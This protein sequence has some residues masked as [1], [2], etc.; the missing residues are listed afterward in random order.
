MRKTALLFRSTVAAAVFLM[1]GSSYAGQGERLANAKPSAA[2]KTTTVPVTTVVTALGPNFTA[3]PAISKDDVAVYS[4]NTRENVAS[5]DAAR[6]AK[7]GLQ[8]AILIDDDDSPTALG[9]HF[10]EIKDFIG[11]QPP[12]TEVG[13]Y[14][15]SAGS[16]RPAAAFSSDHQA[17]AKKLRLPLG[18]SFGA[19]PSVYLSL[20]DLARNWPPNDKRHEVLMIASGIDRLHP[21]LQSPYVDQA[22]NQVQKSGIVVHTIYT[23][24]LHLARSPLLQQVGWQNLSRLADASGGQSFFQGFETPVDFL[25]IFHKLNMALGNQ[26]LL[27]VDM[28][29]SEE[30]NGQLRPIHIRTE[31]RNLHLSYASEVFV[32]GPASERPGA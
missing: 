27:T 31:Q 15:A 21:D 17:V 9:S 6:G 1:V 13:I 18:K 24:G 12:T 14:Y 23:G 8:L 5:F 2:P 26:Y 4:G 16:A 7:A 11:A 28:P 25:P 19:S 29:G 10:Q 20:K 22:V 32:P 3:P 30:K